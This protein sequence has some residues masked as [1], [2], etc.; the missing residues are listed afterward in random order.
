MMWFSKHNLGTDIVG[1]LILKK[2]KF[3]S[4][5]EILCQEQEIHL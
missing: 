2:I 3:I 4:W 1:N 5:E